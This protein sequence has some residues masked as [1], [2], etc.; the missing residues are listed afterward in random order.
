MDVGAAFFH[1]SVRSGPLGKTYSGN[2]SGASRR[3]LLQ[4]LRDL[5]VFALTSW[6]NAIPVPL[7]YVIFPSFLSYATV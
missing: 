6:R 7:V 3:I 4:F 2:V 5:L 1:V